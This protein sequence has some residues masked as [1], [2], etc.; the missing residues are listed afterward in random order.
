MLIEGAGYE[1]KEKEIAEKVGIQADNDIDT[2]NGVPS[3][4]PIGDP[5]KGLSS[6]L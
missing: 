5:F 1:V 6:R 3:V 4:D 2:Y